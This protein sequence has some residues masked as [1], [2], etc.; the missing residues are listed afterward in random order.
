[1]IVFEARAS[2]IVY[3]LLRSR[4][5]DRPFLVPAN[6]C[7]I[8]PITFLKARRRYCLVDI[9]RDLQAP[10]PEQCLDLVTRRR[11]EFGG[12]LHVR[13]Y[14]ADA[15]AEP[16]LRALKAAQPDL[17]TI[18]DRCLSRPDL[19][20]AALAPSADVTLFS[21][22]RVK[23][24]D[25]G[26]GGFAHIRAGVPYRRRRGTFRAA[27]LAWLTRRYQVA[28]ADR[29][30]FRRGTG[31]WLDLARPRPSWDAYRRRVAAAAAAA[32]AHRRALN[33]IYADA[34]PLEVQLPARFQGWRFNIMV[35]DPDR[36][37][38]GLARVGLFAGRHYASLGGILGEGRFPVAE[39]LH[40]RI[41]NLF[42]DHHYDEPMARRT[43]DL[44]N[45]YLRMRA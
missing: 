35:P 33:A 1:M 27:E 11:G 16:F 34:L 19:S 13:T 8:V 6:V 36:F 15:A 38:R 39:A 45:A 22:G 37:V 29:R 44:V 43:A 28:L 24:V 3:N 2:T 41:V 23:P 40:A 32:D 25:V 26:L 12:V 42:N 14:G 10:D 4:R 18:D 30:P 31:A 21:T 20:G 9:G 5:D 7:S 17:L